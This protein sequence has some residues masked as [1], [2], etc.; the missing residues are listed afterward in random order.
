MLFNLKKKK[1]SFRKPLQKLVHGGSIIIFFRNTCSCLQQA[2]STFLKTKILAYMHFTHGG[3]VQQKHTGGA[4]QHTLWW[5]CTKQTHWWS[6]T[7]E[8]HWWSCTIHTVVDL[9]NTNTLV[10]LSLIHI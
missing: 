4:V 2:K 10:E 8:T 5:S 1:I 7:T 6:C 3:A 9:Y